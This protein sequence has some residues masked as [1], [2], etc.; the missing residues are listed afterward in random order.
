MAHLLVV[1]V[2]SL[3][4]EFESY[5]GRAI[6]ISGVIVVGRDDARIS[7]PQDEGRGIAISAASLVRALEREGWPM[8][9]TPWRFKGAGYVNATPVRSSSGVLLESVTWVHLEQTRQKP[10]DVDV[11][12]YAPDGPRLYP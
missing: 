1:D 4:R 10:L 5:E 9:G 6:S 11:T 8:I 12:K 7:D 2:S 3:L